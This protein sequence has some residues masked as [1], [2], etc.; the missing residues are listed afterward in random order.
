MMGNIIKII[1]ALVHILWRHRAPWPLIWGAI[2]KFRAP[3]APGAL[4]GK[5]LSMSS[6]KIW[7]YDFKVP[8][9]KSYS[10]LGRGQSTFSPLSMQLGT[11][12][13]SPIGSEKPYLSL[14]EVSHKV[15]TLCFSLVFFLSCKEIIYWLFVCSWQKY[16]IHMHIHFF[17]TMTV[18][19]HCCQMKDLTDYSCI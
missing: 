9:R 14:I 12:C 13:F 7:I 18:Y 10:S 6:T 16:Q 11:R 5:P 15:P 8:T 17:S 4:L 2:F 19:L 3:M 1:D